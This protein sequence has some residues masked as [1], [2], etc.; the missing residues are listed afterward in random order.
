MI[1][2]PA[3]IVTALTDPSIEIAWLIKIVDNLN[4]ILMTTWSENITSGSDTYKA[5]EK[6]LSI[7]P[8]EGATINGSLNN[9][10][11]VRIYDEGMRL[12][13]CVK[14][15]NNKDIRLQAKI[16]LFGSSLMTQSIFSGLISAVNIDDNRLTISVEGPL[17]LADSNPVFL[18]NSA[19]KKRKSGDNSLSQ[20]IR[21]I[22]LAWIG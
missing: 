17:S 13:D 9:R 19:Q 18:T 20:L 1:T 5:S 10:A 3:N 12:F 4:V 14:P 22:Y 21:D 11:E 8:P 2:L 6:I 16:V 15:F 7:M